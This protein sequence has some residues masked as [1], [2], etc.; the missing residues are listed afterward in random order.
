M[1]NSKYFTEKEAITSKTAKEL[2]IKNIPTDKEKNIF[3]IQQAVWA[4]LESF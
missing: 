3:N 4:T 1:L 2:K